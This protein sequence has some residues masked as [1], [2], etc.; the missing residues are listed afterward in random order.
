MLS[1]SC[2]PLLA[3]RHRTRDVAADAAD[4]SSNLS[5]TVALCVLLVFLCCS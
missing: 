5:I 4:A 1:M 2:A 3:Q